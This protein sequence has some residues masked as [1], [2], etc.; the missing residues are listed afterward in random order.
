MSRFWLRF[1]I[2][3]LVCAEIAAS[4]GAAGAGACTGAGAGALPNREPKKDI[5]V[6]MMRSGTDFQRTNK[7][8]LSAFPGSATSASP[9]RGEF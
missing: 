5:E 9:K 8:A 4:V 7:F 3:S 2:A 6:K 1:A